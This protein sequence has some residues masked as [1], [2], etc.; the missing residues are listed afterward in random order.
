M[1]SEEQVEKAWAD[2]VNCEIDCYF[3]NRTKMQKQLDVLR[4][5]AEQQRAE[6]RNA[7]LEWQPIETA[8]KDGSEVLLYY[9]LEGL[10][11]HH[12]RRVICWWHKGWSTRSPGR[13]VFQGRA[14]RGYSDE[15]QPTLWMPLPEPPQATP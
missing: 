3:G 14:A 12:S 6:A 4:A 15:Y 11:E 9:P 7:A 13:W 1:A 10:S 2:F 8:P 5:F